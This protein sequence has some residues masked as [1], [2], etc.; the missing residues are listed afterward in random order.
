MDPAIPQGSLALVRQIPASEIRIGDVVTVDRERML[1]VTHRVTSVSDSPGVPHGSRSITMRGDANSSDDSAVYTVER[2]RIVMASVPGLASVIVALS[3]PLVIGTLALGAAGIVTWAFWPR[4]GDRNDVVKRR[5]RGAARTGAAIATL[6][7]L[8]ALHL[9][10]PAPAHAAETETV[11]HGTIVTLTAIGDIHLM[12]NLIVGQP[13][14]WQVGVQA[15]PPTPGTVHIG[16]S[17]DGALSLPGGLHVSIRACTIRWVDGVCAGAESVWLPQQ[18]L[19][20]AIVP[21]TAFVARELGSMPSNEQRWLLLEATLPPGTAPGA[22]ASVFIQAWGTGE[23]VSIGVGG[24]SSI[25]ASISATGHGVG[26][27]VSLA[28]LAIGGGI[29]VATVARRRRDT[30]ERKS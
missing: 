3:H 12:E 13:V 14:P 18:D 4:G 24:A 25:T 5:A 21:V 26:W 1:P 30:R 8:V 17:A 28:F 10:E 9:A 6:P 29:G 16:I 27:P 22:F 15:A 20:T 23:D 11:V 2:V 7:V 19:A